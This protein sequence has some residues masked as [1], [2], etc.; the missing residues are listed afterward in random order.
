MFSE[1]FC[2][3]NPDCIVTLDADGTMHYVNPSGVALWEFGSKQAAI[4]KRFA[5][6]WPADD[7]GKIRQAIATASIRPST[8]EGFCVT[9]AGNRYWLETRFLS[10]KRRSDEPAT[11]LC[12]SRDFS[13]SEKAK[14][15]LTA[16]EVKDRAQNAL[17][18]EIIDSAIDTAII[19]TDPE[20]QIIL[21]SQGARQITGWNDEEMLGRPLATIF[22]PE[23]RTAGRPALEMR[24]AD[25]TGRASDMRWHETK[26]GR[27]FYAH[28]SINPI[29]GPAGGYVK[30]FRDATQQ[31][32]TESALK[33]SEDRYA[34]LFN[35]IDSGFCIVDME[36]DTQQHPA[37]YRFVEVNPAFA[38]NTGL[39]AVVG[40]TIRELVPTIEQTP[41]RVSASRT[42]PGRSAIDGTRCTLFER[43]IRSGIVLPFSS[44]IFRIAKT[45]RRNYVSAKLGSIMP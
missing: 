21:W 10:L 5:D 20:G 41:V 16:E 44:R 45:R 36:F 22:T 2:E 32:L 26:D 11:I 34:S 24:R 23:D 7:Q 15:S 3:A 40:K 33:E 42:A 38:T 30:S 12:I 6:L 13:A 29:L 1:E 27:R 18:R 4:G 19:G 17:Y 28:G 43:A 37:D 14:K 31:H 8:I 25:E 9:P 35:S 39:S